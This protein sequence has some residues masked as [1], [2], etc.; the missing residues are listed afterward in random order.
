MGEHAAQSDQRVRLGL[1]EE[2]LLYKDEC[3]YERQARVG[4]AYAASGDPPWAEL[5]HRADEPTRLAGVLN[6]HTG[7]VHAYACHREMNRYRLA[8]FYQEVREAY[9]EAKRIWLV[10][11]NHAFHFHPDVL[12]ALEPQ[13]CPFPFKRPKTWPDEPSKLAIRRYGEWRL[14]IQLVLLPTY[15][16]WLNPIEKVWRKLK[17]EFLYLH[18]HAA[19]SPEELQQRV[20]DFLHQWST[21]STDLLRYVGLLSKEPKERAA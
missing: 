6:A 11:D 1:G 20:L 12:V 7:A 17:Q 5:S 19:D 18:R 14:P 8:E 9:P 4:A 21:R 16:P 10:Q 3:S 15:A 13:E 2:V